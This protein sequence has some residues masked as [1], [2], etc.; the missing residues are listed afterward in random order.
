MHALA[1]GWPVEIEIPE[2]RKWREL[3]LEQQ[4]PSATCEEALKMS[5]VRQS[6]S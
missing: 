4:R 3:L 6:K 1:K 2:Y 5:E